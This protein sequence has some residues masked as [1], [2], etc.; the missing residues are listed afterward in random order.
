M[1]TTAIAEKGLLVVARFLDG[2]ILK[3]TTHDFAPNKTEF[4]LHLEGNERSRAVHVGVESL[5]ALFFVR[6][7]GGNSQRR[8][9]YAFESVG[10]QGGRK[11]RVRFT[12]GE[13]IAGFTA[14]YSPRKQGFFLVP[15]DSE[16]N[17]ARVYI[18]NRAVAKVEWL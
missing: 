3:G 17:N 10:S 1:P 7:F 2:T 18:L 12:D 11:I 5:K 15:A 16:G 8:D 6:S 4:H 13:E 14:A 9:D